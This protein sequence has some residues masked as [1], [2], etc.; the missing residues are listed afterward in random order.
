MGPS[1]YFSRV[2]AMARREIWTGDARRVLY[3]RLVELFGPYE[4]WEKAASPGRGREE[5]FDEFCNVFAQTVGAKSGRAV[6]HQ[7]MFALPETESGSVWHTQAQ[8]AILN[9]AAA[10]EAGFIRDKHLP[11]LLAVGRIV[12]DTKGQDVVALDHG[13]QSMRYTGL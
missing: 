12:T 7:I 5:E 8:A 2:E 10:L 13:D 1:Q 3:R 4:E 11:N 6:Q 9:K